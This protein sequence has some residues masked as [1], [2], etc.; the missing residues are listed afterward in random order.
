MG[1]PLA[2]TES[3]H[4]SQAEEPKKETLEQQSPILGA[5]EISNE[6]AVDEFIDTSGLHFKGS[7]KGES[8]T[9]GPPN[10]TNSFR[11]HHASVDAGLNKYKEMSRVSLNFPRSG[12]H[13]SS[14]VHLEEVSAGYYSIEN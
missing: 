6:E 12:S 10:L 5:P 3:E 1:R 8:K 9:P 14:I 7:R 11:K 2:A 13:L 4:P